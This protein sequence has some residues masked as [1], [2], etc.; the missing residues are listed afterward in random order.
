LIIVV[1]VSL[2][3]GVGAASK[4]VDPFATVLRK[5]PGGMLRA[6]FDARFPPRVGQLGE[7]LESGMVVGIVEVTGLDG[8][9][10]RLRPVTAAGEKAVRPR[11]DVHWAPFVASAGSSS[12]TRVLVWSDE[13]KAELFVNGDEVGALPRQVMLAVGQYRLEARFPDGFT[14]GCLWNPTL[15]GAVVRLS[16]PARPT[17][18]RVAAQLES[19]VGTENEKG[20]KPTLSWLDFP[21]GARFLRSWGGVPKIQGV[22]SKPPKYPVNLR[23]RRIQGRALLEAAIGPDGKVVGVQ[24]ISATEPEFGEASAI[25]VRQWTFRPLVFHGRRVGFLHP[26][27]V[28]FT[29]R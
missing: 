5:G 4:P 25:A 7:V 18:S 21:S 26:V 6:R 13:P 10:A 19:S 1:L 20:K 3:V 8:G 29:L 28:R 15:D 24:V 11:L 2:A 14:A 12:S 17:D 23:I 16:G 22:E 27:E 9:W